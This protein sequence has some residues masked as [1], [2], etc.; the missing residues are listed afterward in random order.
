M[1][2]S[3]EVSRWLELRAGVGATGKKTPGAPAQA[4]A[5]VRAARGAPLAYVSSSGSCSRIRRAM[6]L[7]LPDT[8]LHAREGPLG[9]GDAGSRGGLG[10]PDLPRTCAPR[11]PP[12]RG[13]PARRAAG[14]D[15]ASSCPLRVGAGA[16]GSRPSRRRG[17]GVGTGFALGVQ[18]L[19]TQSRGCFGRCGDEAGAV[20]LAGSVRHSAGARSAAAFVRACAVHFP[21]RHPASL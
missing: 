21:T 9:S 11:A 3:R 15:P 13:Q 20:S 6:M 2:C 1:A 10:A 19:G 14:W 7:T 18:V 4:P 8:K 16:A 5:R 17:S 12:S